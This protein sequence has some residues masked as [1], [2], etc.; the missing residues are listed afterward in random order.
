M[1]DLR[2]R[3][4]DTVQRKTEAEGTPG[5]RTLVQLV[6]RRKVQRK[7]VAPAGPEA[8]AAAV[9]AAA[10]AAADPAAAA[11]DPAAAAAAVA[12]APAPAEDVTAADPA[13][14]EAAAAAAD[15]AAAEASAEPDPAAEPVQAKA[16]GA[17]AEDP[18]DV[19]AAAAEG[20]AGSGGAMPH[21]EAIQSAFG[22]HDISGVKAH[23]D[24]KAAAAAGAMGAE[25]YATGNDVAFAGAP[26]LHTAAHEAAHVV[27]QKEGVQL[28]GGVGAVGDPYEQH[29]D[30]VADAVVAGGSAE[31]LLSAGPGGGGAG[32]AVQRAPKPPAAPAAAPRPAAPRPAAA[33]PG[34]PPAAP[35]AAPKMT[36]AQAK[37]AI[38]AKA[39]DCVDLSADF[40][41]DWENKEQTAFDL[42]FADPNKLRAAVITKYLTPTANPM[43]IKNVGSKDPVAKQKFTDVDG[44]A[45]LDPLHGDLKTKFY[46][47]LHPELLK[48]TYTDRTR[49]Y[50]AQK[51]ATADRSFNA[52]GKAIPADRIS[53]FCARNHS[54]DNLYRLASVPRKAEIDAQ[55]AAEVTAAGGKAK[56]IQTAQ[57]DEEVRKKAYRHILATGGDPL[58]GIPKTEMIT[59]WPTWCAPGEIKVGAG[60]PNAEFAAMMTLGALQP[61]WYPNGTCVLNIDRRISGGARTL[62]KPTAFDGLMSALWTS[63]NMTQDDYGVTG[64]GLGEF[65][66]KNIPFGDVTSAK[67]IIPTDDFLADIKRVT[68]EVEKKAPGSTPTEE[69]VRGNKENTKILNTTGTGTGGAKDMYGQIT[70]KTKKEQ[71][72]PS[73]APVAPLAAQPT[74]VPKTPTASAEPALPAAPAPAPAVA[75]PPKGLTTAPAPGVPAATGPAPSAGGLQANDKR[76]VGQTAAGAPA[77]TDG[78]FGAAPN[79]TVA[80]A[81]EAKF[82]PQERDSRFNP[83]DKV[84]FEKALAAALLANAQLYM[85]EVNGVSGR[86]LSYFES[87]LK[88]G[89]TAGVAGARAKYEADLA[90]LT[91]ESKPGWWGAVE[92]E[93]NATQSD[94]A[95]KTKESLMNGALPQKLS[96]HQNF[97]GVIKNDF[98]SPD[99]IAQGIL[100]ASAQVPWYPRQQCKLT[101]GKL[102]PVNGTSVF[103]GPSGENAAQEAERGRVGT[104]DQGAVSPAGPGIEARD[105]TGAAP[106]SVLPPG[107]DAQ[108]VNRGL[109]AF[110]MDEAKDFCQRA[111][112][113]INMPLAAGVSGS[114]ADLIGAAMSLGTPK[115]QLMKYAVAVIAYIS[116]GGNHSYNEIVIVMKAAGLDI[117]PDTYNGVEQLIGTPLFQQL[118]TAHPNAFKTPAA[119]GAVAAP[120]A[121]P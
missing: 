7:P 48:A 114:T 40:A 15:P 90:L 17:R 99:K 94:L 24:D 38:D 92:I 58:T 96:V 52:K 67:S 27:Q 47:K 116:G 79:T 56:A 31:A 98:L 111:R 54:V 20:V 121:G 37:A 46:Q 11:A 30:A 44:E 101:A 104:S 60:A 68:T 2:T 43:L 32:A 1:K 13:A 10:P 97:Y 29:A 61:E 115:E 91:T 33:A 117:D 112:L 80:A 42:Q 21:G 95:A 65:L 63:R 119:P 5:K 51:D 88:G 25:A 118:K 64:G 50:Q 73:P 110:T 84:N 12:T 102:D 76:N 93:A 41:K 77:R 3:S 14:A 4:T 108:M 34:A 106:E 6:Q 86:I 100:G 72:T 8:V 28:A 107:Q 89:M 87:R 83:V 70:D 49:T 9:A 109:D 81:A 45:H 55:I 85:A 36:L 105:A 71:A 59:T 57:A 39:P 78:D 18:A 75:P 66:E 69:L 22:D 19:Q 26:S 23:T 113:V 62:I 103:K 120:P 16:D 35:A 82:G 74:P 53:P